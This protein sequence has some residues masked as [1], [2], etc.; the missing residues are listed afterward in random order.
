MRL[1]PTE[2]R[3]RPAPYPEATQLFRAPFTALEADEGENS[4]GSTFVTE[5]TVFSYTNE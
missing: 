3:A 4:K 2:Q 5:T 1:K